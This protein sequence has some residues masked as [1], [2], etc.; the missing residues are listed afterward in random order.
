M[1]YKLISGQDMNSYPLPASFPPGLNEL[2]VFGFHLGP[3]TL[4]FAH[5]VLEFLNQLGNQGGPNMV[6]GGSRPGSCELT[7]RCISPNEPVKLL[8]NLFSQL[9]EVIQV[10]IQSGPELFHG[11]CI[12]RVFDLFIAFLQPAVELF[13]IH[14]ILLHIIN[15]HGEHFEAIWIISGPLSARLDAILFWM[16][17]FLVH[18]N[19]EGTV[20]CLIHFSR[21]PKFF[22][23]CAVGFF[24]DNSRRFPEDVGKEN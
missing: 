2:P 6:I 16:V 5:H 13:Q 9:E 3:E 24:V 8:V 19:P 17:V 20:K 14:Q 12:L 22:W 7:L 23:K 10:H 15:F 18:V 11:L 21:Y 4:E 1:G